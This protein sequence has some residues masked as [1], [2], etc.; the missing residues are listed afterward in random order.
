M[1][2]EGLLSREEAVARIDPGQ[3]DQLLHPTID[4]AAEYEVAGKGLNASPGAATGRIVLDADRAE[5]QGKADEAVI[6]VRAETTPDDIHG[7]IEARGVLTAHGGMT[8]HAAVVARG[9][10]KP[11]VAGCE[12]LSID[13]GELRI[14]LGERELAEGDVITIN[15]GTGEVIVGEGALVAPQINQDFQTVLEWA[16]TMRPLGVRANAD[17]PEDAAKARELGAEGIGLCR[18]EHMFFA[19]GRLPLVREMIMAESEEGRRDA[20]ERLL[21]VQQGDFEAIFEA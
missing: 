14:R 3:L 1:V 17:T 15:G 10:G 12:A 4:P 13:L 21:P 19:E 20:L 5:E 16:D 7:I 9:M 18:T 8:S 6:L 2:G 11:C